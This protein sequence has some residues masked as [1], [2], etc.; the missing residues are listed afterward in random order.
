M[1]SDDG[2]VEAEWVMVI[3]FV[4]KMDNC[5]T[6]TQDDTP[7]DKVSDIMR[8]IPNNMCCSKGNIFVILGETVP[9][10][11]N[12]VRCAASKMGALCM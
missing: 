8:Q 12:D 3:L 7:T 4:V 1:S 9:R 5:K 2:E 6:L 10:W 11:S